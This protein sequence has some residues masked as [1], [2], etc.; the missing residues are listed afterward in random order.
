MRLKLYFVSPSSPLSYSLPIPLKV[1]ALG[2]GKGK[3][4]RRDDKERGRTEPHIKQK[5]VVGNYL[6]W[7]FL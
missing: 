6:T 4:N 3:E 7:I 2:K 1:G 5:G